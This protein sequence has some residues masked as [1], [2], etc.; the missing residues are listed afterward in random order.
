M[1]FDWVSTFI[2]QRPYRV[3]HKKLTHLGIGQ[4]ADSFADVQDSVLKVFGPDH[5]LAVT[6]LQVPKLVD[7]V[8]NRE[9]LDIV[10]CKQDAAAAC[11]LLRRE[12]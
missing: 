12:V 2:V 10:V 5:R 7:V 6:P 11:N 9:C 1:N 4:V 3:K 8:T